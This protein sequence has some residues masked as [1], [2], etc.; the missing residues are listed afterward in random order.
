MKRFT[1]YT[2]KYANE[3]DE[4]AAKAA[5]SEAIYIKRKPNNFILS[6]TVS[7][8]EAFFEMLLA[9]LTDIAVRENSVY[10]YSA[11]LR[12]MAQDLRNTPLYGRELRQLREFVSE[13]NELHIEG[14]VTFRMC[15][16]REKLD[17]MIYSLVKKIKFG[18]GE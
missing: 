10:R 11:K 7:Q 16:F 1:I 15:E 2:V 9:V 3:L 12:E 8:R 17:T 13:S 18:T 4:F 6:F 5:A 14:Y